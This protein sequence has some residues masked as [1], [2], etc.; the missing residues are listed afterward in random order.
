VTRVF[1]TNGDYG[2]ST[3]ITILPNTI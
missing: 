2:D 3:T 1:T